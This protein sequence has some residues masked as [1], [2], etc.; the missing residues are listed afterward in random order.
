M[1]RI[2]FIEYA[3]WWFSCRRDALKVLD[4]A[5]SIVRRLVAASELGGGLEDWSNPSY[6]SRKDRRGHLDGTKVLIVLYVRLS[7]YQVGA[8]GG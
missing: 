6:P 3:G 1:Q 2:F 7:R 4:S 5:W 8:I